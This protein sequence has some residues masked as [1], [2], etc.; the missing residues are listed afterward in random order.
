[1]G[2]KKSPHLTD[3]ELRLMQV[4][5]RKKK[6][7]VGEVVEALEEDL[8]YNTVL[9]IMSILEKKGYV[10]HEKEGRAFVYHPVVNRT[11]A[12]RSAV[13]YI[14]SRFFNNSPELLVLHILE[15][16]KISAKELKRLKKMIEES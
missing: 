15:N 2:R 16:E 11:E 13:Q 8:A 3:A 9:T 12:G 10:R 6:A 7:T 14:A 1:M 4:L 5:W